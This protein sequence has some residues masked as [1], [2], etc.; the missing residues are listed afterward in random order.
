MELERVQQVSAER[1][2]G[3]G[4]RQ[5]NSGNC[6]SGL[7]MLCSDPDWNSKRCRRA[8]VRCFGRAVWGA[9]D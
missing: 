4:R 3:R 8:G 1:E 7:L 2:Y 6:R 9:E 5:S